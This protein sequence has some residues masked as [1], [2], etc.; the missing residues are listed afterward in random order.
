MQQMESIPLWKDVLGQKRWKKEACGTK[1][2]IANIKQQAKF[3]RQQK[4]LKAAI[5]QVSVGKTQNTD[6][7]F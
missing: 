4:W 5:S 6:G 2:S 1:S 3:G 7:F